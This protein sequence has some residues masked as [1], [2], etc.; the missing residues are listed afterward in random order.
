M[1]GEDQ[2]PDENQTAPADTSPLERDIQRWYTS[3]LVNVG[4][5]IS[6]DAYN[7]LSNARDGLNQILH[8]ARAANS[9]E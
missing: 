9:G 7:A 6:T 5:M 3:V 8:A 2:K 4:P 1:T